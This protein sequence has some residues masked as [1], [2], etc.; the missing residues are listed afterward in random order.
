MEDSRTSEVESTVSDDEKNEDGM[1]SFVKEDPTTSGEKSSG[2]LLARAPCSELGARLTWP[3]VASATL[4]RISR[5]AVPIKVLLF[6]FQ[7]PY[8][9][10]SPSES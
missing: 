10:V 6:G 5:M 8:K 9:Y 3:P 7:S 2:I 4:A 1:P